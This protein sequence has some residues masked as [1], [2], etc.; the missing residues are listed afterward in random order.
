MHK[1][2]ETEMIRTEKLMNLAVWTSVPEW[3]KTIYGL[4]W[5]FFWI[6]AIAA[7]IALIVLGRKA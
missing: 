1:M 2:G 3:E 7:G 4:G 6:G 5:T